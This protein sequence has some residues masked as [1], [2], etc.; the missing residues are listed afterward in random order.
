MTTEFNFGGSTVIAVDFDG[1]IHR[2]SKGWQD[3]AIYDPPMAGCKEALENLMEQGCHIVIHSARKD[4][5]AIEEWM[6]KHQIPFDR[7][8]EHGPK[9]YA[10]FYLDDKGLRF[11]NW[12]QA[13]DDI[14]MFEKQRRR[15]P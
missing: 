12:P 5:A 8:A 10:H 1:V 13:V 11:E 14:V 9:P 6:K 15:T 3:G 4:T 2:Y 7:F